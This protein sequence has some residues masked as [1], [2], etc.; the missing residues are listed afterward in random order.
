MAGVQPGIGGHFRPSAQHFRPRHLGQQ[1]PGQG[2]ADAAD[3]EQQVAFTAQVGILVDGLGDGLVHRLELGREVVDRRRCHGAGSVIDQAAGAAVLPLG[4]AADEA[5]ARGLQLAPPP[6]R[7]RGRSPGRRLEQLAVFADPRG[8]DPVCLVAAELG[9][10]EVAD[11][12]RVDDADAVTGLLQDQRHAEAV[13]A[14]RF[15]ADMGLLDAHGL[16]PGQQLPPA[17][18]T[19]GEAPALPASASGA[20]RVQRVLGNIN[21]ETGVVHSTTIILQDYSK[22]P[23]RTTLYTGS[24]VRCVPGYRP[25]CTAELGRAGAN[26]LVGLFGQGSNPASPLSSPP[27]RYDYPLNCSQR[28]RSKPRSRSRRSTAWW[29]LDARTPSAPPERTRKQGN[30]CPS[31]LHA[32]K[33]PGA[34]RKM[35]ARPAMLPQTCVPSVAA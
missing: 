33:Y 7:R 4:Q 22:A 35:P 28:T 3:A 1:D 16:E 17:L 24:A 19:I 25:V 26:L 10:D 11:L 23:H 15:Q 8:I 13:A 2:L 21:T 29:A 12:G 20:V 27:S 31:R 32:P 18:G 5:G 30:S 9:A 34:A 6:Q 14:G